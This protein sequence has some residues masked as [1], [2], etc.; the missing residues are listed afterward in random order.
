V[1]L[2]NPGPTNTFKE[3]KDVQSEN[4]DICH[5]TEDF[6]KKY[7][8][9][10][11]KLIDLYNPDNKSLWSVS[12][13]CGSGTAALEA[14]ILSLVPENTTVIVAGKYGSRAV[15]ILINN[16]IKHSVIEVNNI[17]ELTI[18]T[19]IKNVYFV[20][21]ETTTGEK[22]SIEKMSGLYPNAKFY[23]DA[24]SSF[25]AS[26]YNGYEGRIKAISF[27]SNKCLQSS[28]GLGMVIY[29]KSCSFYDRSSF[30]LNLKKYKEDLPFTVPPQLITALLKSLEINNYLPLKEVFDSRR[31]KLINDL[32]RMGINCIN[33]HPSNSVIGFVHPVMDYKELS[34][35]LV[36]KDIV[37]Y[38]GI[39]NVDNSF[40]ISTMSVVFD[41]LYKYILE[42][43]NDSCLC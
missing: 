25:G 41:N 16:S 11:E 37:I 7:E 19:D 17:D 5:R 30:Y 4:T 27:C 28:A 38:S 31:D 22:F 1:I 24:T 20:E 6:L 15:E 35:F 26:K 3:V 34:D 14:M 43:F 18:D 32:K 33:K 13:L 8:N 40:R 12:I 23:I 29:Q 39:P 2:L 10:K 21:N 36:T 42:S 9:L